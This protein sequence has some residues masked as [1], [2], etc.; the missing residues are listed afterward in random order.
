MLGDKRK[1][2]EGQK[3]YTLIVPRQ[4]RQVENVRKGKRK[5]KW[6]GEGTAPHVVPDT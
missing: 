2:S 4:Q 5:D 6:N 3:S 1:K